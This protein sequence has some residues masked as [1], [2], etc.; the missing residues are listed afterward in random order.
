MGL[1][2]SNRCLFKV[3]VWRYAILLTGLLLINSSA[4]AAISFSKTPEEEVMCQ[5]KI[6]AGHDT[7]DREN[8]QHM[9]HY[10]DCVRFINRAYTAR[11][12]YDRDEALQTAIG[13]CGYVLG[14]T[15]P[16]FYMRAEVMTQMAIGQK[17]LGQHAQA[18]GTLIKA[19][20]FDSN[21]VPAYVELS[22]YYREMGD[23]KKALGLIVEGLKREPDS[24]RLKRSYK[25]L[26]GKLPYPE[27][28][29]PTPVEAAQPVA[30][31]DKEIE[32]PSASEKTAND[33]PAS[34]PVVAPEEPATTPN[35]GTPKNPY[36][37]FCTE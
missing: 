13:G 11:N 6:Y 1:T 36:C 10:C 2:Q 22:D 18:A 20:Q 24:K 32:A 26:G 25:E 7:S 9:H 23:K 30:T 5:A 21:Y 12:R 33:T 29:Q 4:W 19:I 34:A 3:F 35:I 17:M 15:K 8:W 14:H 31:T 27:P 37:R 16:D 28:I